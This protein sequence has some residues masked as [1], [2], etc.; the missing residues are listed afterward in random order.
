[1]DHFGAED[2]IWGFGDVIFL[3]DEEKKSLSEAE[4]YEVDMQREAQM[5]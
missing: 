4:M 1:M 2:R 3:V 5:T